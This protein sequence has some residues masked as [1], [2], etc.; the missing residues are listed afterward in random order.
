[1]SGDPVNRPPRF[2]FAIA[3]PVMASSYLAAD[4]KKRPGRY[5]LGPLHLS[6]RL[7]LRN[8]GVDTNVLRTRRRTLQDRSVLLRPSVVAFLPVGRRLRL[9][10]DGYLDAQ[11]Y[12]RAGSQRSVDFG[13]DARARLDLGRATLF[14]GGGGLQVHQRFAPDLEPLVAP[15]PFD[16]DR[17]LLRQE[18]WGSLGVTLKVSQKITG[19]AIE[20]GRSYRSASLSVDGADV[21]K[22]LDHNTT[23]VSLQGRYALTHRTSLVAL[24]DVV[25]DRFL[26]GTFGGSRVIRSYRYLAGAELGRR[27]WLRGK[28]LAGFRE[29]PGSASQAAPSYRGPVLSV[30]TELPLFGYARLGAIAERDVQYSATPVLVRGEEHRN[31]YV[32]GRYWASLLVALPLGFTGRGA[33]DFE[34]ARYVLPALVNGASARRVDHF[35]AAGASLLR[36]MGHRVR[37]GG[38]VSWEQRIS[39][40]PDFTY[41]AVTYGLQAEIVP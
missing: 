35:W 2:V 8:A 18:R 7:E 13:L 10:S 22:W 16:L 36:R 38:N 26:S 9:E 25:E 24:A 23:T 21:R 28:V 33:A 1:M 31:T 19:T 37:L 4:T 14:G 5:R 20:S 34:Q 27:A 11:Y 39:N 29:F 40:F 15:Q 3:L 17:R 6:P 32:L 41:Q 30:S 12:R